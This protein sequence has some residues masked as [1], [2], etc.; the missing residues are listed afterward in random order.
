MKQGQKIS[1]NIR[2]Y[3]HRKFRTE[4]TEIIFN[5]VPKVKVRTKINVSFLTIVIKNSMQSF[6]V[7]WPFLL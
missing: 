4:N 2:K 7:H 3:R 1:S 6:H 5:R